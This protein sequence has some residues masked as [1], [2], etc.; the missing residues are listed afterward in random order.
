MYNSKK[1]LLLIGLG[2]LFLSL[3]I[4]LFLEPQT[5][6]TGG[7]TGIGVI[8]ERLSM[9]KLGFAIPIWVTNLAVNI[10]LLIVAYRLQGKT[11]LKKTIYGTLVLSLFLGLTEGLPDMAQDN[12]LA[13]VF[14]GVLSGVGVGLI[15]KGEGTTGGSDLLATLLNKGLDIKVSSLLFIIDSIIILTGF[16]VFGRMSAMY[17]IIAVYISTRVVDMVAN[18]VNYAKVAFVLSDEPEKISNELMTQLRRGVTVLYGKGCYTGKDKNVLMVVAGSRQIGRL[19][20]LI[21]SIDESAFVFI[22]DVREVMGYF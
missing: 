15:F 11:M 17:S 12:F 18:G 21:W 3:A 13:A 2:A 19:K 10:P 20:Q 9:E 4:N 5:L 16:F 14:G 8:I 22:A 6:V 7:A 1:G